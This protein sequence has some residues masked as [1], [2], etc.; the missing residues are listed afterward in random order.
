M[1]KR[2]ILFLLI[3]VVSGCSTLDKVKRLRTFEE[4]ENQFRKLIIN[5]RFEDAGRFV[6]ESWLKKHPLDPET[7]MLFKVTDYDVKKVVFSEDQRRIDMEIIIRYYRTDQL[8]EQSIRDHQKWMFDP[9]LN[10]WVLEN[11]LPPFR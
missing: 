11:G 1:V 8:V 9:R 3:V 7:M 5:S 2:H 6:G 4:T 10:H